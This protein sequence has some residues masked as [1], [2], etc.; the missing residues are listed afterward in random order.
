[1]LPCGAAQPGAGA[2][3]GRQDRT[4]RAAARHIDLGKQLLPPLHQP[5]T[6]QGHQ[7][8]CAHLHGA[9]VGAV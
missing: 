4:A 6:Q 8:E 3:G 7:G 5:R 2:S 9:H 1:M